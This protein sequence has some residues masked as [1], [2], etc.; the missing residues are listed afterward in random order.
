MNTKNNKRKKATLEK[1]EKIFTQMLQTKEISQISVSDICKKAE[2]NRSTFYANYI[3]I[4]DLADTIRDKLEIEVNSLY[5]NDTCNKCGIDY[6]KLF[7]HI[8]D[9][10]IFYQTYFKLGY[11]SRHT[12][13]L[14]L[15]AQQNKMFPEEDME[16]HIEFHKAGLNA[17]IKKWLASGCEKSPETMVKIIEEEY[18]RRA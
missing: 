5:D 8:K 14:K 11:D 3:D 4:Y 16:Y 6:L 12:V 10:R 13:D 9:N 15:L 17:V 7:R 2:V 1:I 18:K